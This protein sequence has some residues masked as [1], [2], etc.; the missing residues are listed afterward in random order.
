MIV[1]FSTLQVLVDGNLVKN[2]DLDILFDNSEQSYQDKDTY[3]LFDEI[4]KLTDDV[5]WFYAK[6]GCTT[7]YS[8]DVVDRVNPT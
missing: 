1:S 5:Y 2:K 4:R 8:E 3:Y 6:I 7:P